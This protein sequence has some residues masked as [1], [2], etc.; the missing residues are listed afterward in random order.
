MLR[1][2]FFDVGNTLLYP[3]PSVGEVVRQVLAE[4]GHIHDLARHRRAHAARRRVLRGPLPRRRHVLDERGA[5]PRRCGSACTRCCAAGSA[6]RTTPSGSLARVYDEFG[7]A[8]RWRAYA[9]RRAR[10]RAAA[11]A[12]ACDSASSRTGTVGCTRLLDGLGLGDVARRRSSPRPRSACTSP[13]RASSSWRARGSASSP[14]ECAHVGDHYYAD[15]LGAH[16]G[17]DDAGAHRP[18]RASARV[19]DGRFLRSLDDL[20]DALD[21]ER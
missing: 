2:V 20:E 6:S 1:A 12:R 16:G 5:R 15:I 10:V 18:A 11:R 3:Y 7:D 9:G 8:A 17:R 4:A 14:S 13:I 19:T 21:L